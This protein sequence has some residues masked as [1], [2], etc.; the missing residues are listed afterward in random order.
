MEGSQELRISSFIFF[1][2][3]E[4]DPAEEAQNSRLA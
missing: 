1:K 3:L 2:D 4:N